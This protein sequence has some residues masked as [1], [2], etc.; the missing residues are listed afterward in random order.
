[1]W[2]LTTALALEEVAKLT[3]TRVGSDSEVSVATQGETVI[4]GSRWDDEKGFA[5]GAVYVFDNYRQTQKLTGSPGAFFGHVVA[6]S[7]KLFVGAYGDNA[8]T[9]A[10]Y[11]YR[12]EH[13]FVF[14]Q[15]LL[16][17]AEASFGSRIAVEGN[18]LVVSAY[19]ETTF[20]LVGEVFVFKGPQ[21][22]LVQRLTANQRDLGD[23]FGLAIAI[24]GSRIAVGAPGDDDGGTDA[25]AVYIFEEWRG[26]YTQTRKL[27]ASDARG[28]DRF[29][30]SLAMSGST[31]YVGAPQADSVYTF[32]DLTETKWT[33][34]KQ[35]GWSM[36]LSGSRVV[37][38]ANY[39]DNMTGSAYVFEDGNLTRKLTA[40][41]AKSKDKFGD[42]VAI[43][44]SLIVVA[45]PGQAA[46]YCFG[47]PSSGGSSKKKSMTP[48]VG[49]IVVVVVLL[50][51]AGFACYLRSRRSH[52]YGL[53]LDD[54]QNT[55]KNAIEFP[56]A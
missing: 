5:A 54:L 1:M 46:A 53:N 51:S 20:K 8:L 4:V 3:A 55:P 48:H 29:G 13:E 22:K 14:D 24:S 43:S 23:V 7:D 42:A 52:K 9:G 12:R 33:R 18:T 44:A 27:V 6:L 17:D 37:V 56:P 34:G 10:V 38:G 40:S 32:Q 50:A 25:G 36:A 49:I 19:F 31:L 2:W 28:D 35:M 39:D 15:K 41:D 30:Y 11:V 21:F 45:S 26:N 47:T 16:V